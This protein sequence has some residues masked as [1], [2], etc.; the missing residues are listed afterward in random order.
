ME[1][2]SVLED[3]SRNSVPA[4]DLALEVTHLDLHRILLISSESLMLA[5]IQGREIRPS[6]R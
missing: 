6:A 5:H 4:S 3:H 1:R 2:G